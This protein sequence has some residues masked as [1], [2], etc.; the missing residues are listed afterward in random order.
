MGRLFYVW[1]T[2]LCSRRSQD[3]RS[4]CHWVWRWWNMVRCVYFV[5]STS[6]TIFDGAMRV[7]ALM[8]PAQH[9][10]A[11]GGDGGYVKHTPSFETMHGFS[12]PIVGHHNVQQC[13]GG[14]S[15]SSGL[16]YRWWNQYT[17]LA[18]LARVKRRF[19]QVGEV[20][21][22][23]DRWWLRPPLS[24]VS[25]GY[26]CGASGLHRQT[27]GCDAAPQECKAK[28]FISWLLRMH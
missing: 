15:G 23:S 17:S 14:H 27:L 19:T 7:P 9:D 13:S 10:A 8:C 12:V 6:D 22:G 2:R 11:Q 16:W 5:H 18:N 28:L 26:Q 20:S 4:L 24:W 25:Y 21:G 1:N 3:H